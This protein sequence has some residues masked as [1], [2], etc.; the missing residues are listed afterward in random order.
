MAN[1]PHLSQTLQGLDFFESRIERAGDDDN[2]GDCGPGTPQEDNTPI[3][4]VAK[5]CAEGDL[6]RWI[7]GRK[8]ETEAR[9][10]ERVN[11]QNPITEPVS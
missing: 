7:A 3:Q 6:K 2:P 1:G 9:S 10:C 11:R 5:I 4:R 8:M